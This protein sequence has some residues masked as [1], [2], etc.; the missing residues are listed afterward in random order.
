MAG[1]PVKDSATSAMGFSF[2]FAPK[3]GICLLRY[4]RSFWATKKTPDIGCLD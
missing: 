2:R 3:W 4:K 1:G